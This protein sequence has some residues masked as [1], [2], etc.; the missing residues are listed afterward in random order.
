MLKTFT[1]ILLLFPL[2]LLS[3]SQ[4][5][6]SAAQIDN[7]LENAL[8]LG[9][10]IQEKA[11][12]L[13]LQ[14]YDVS[15]KINYTDGIIRS[16]L[17]AAR[18]SY[19]LGNYKDV[20]AYASEIEQIAK[21]SKN[22]DNIAEIIQLKGKAYTELGF[23]DEG[24]SELK[25]SL[26]LVENITNNDIKYFRKGFIYND[27]AVNLDKAS[28]NLD[29]ITAY[30]EKALASFKKISN[31]IMV[32]KNSCLSLSNS[33]LGSCYNRAG[34]NDLAEKF[35]LN[36][37]DLSKGG[38]NQIKAYTLLEL[39]YL[40]NSKKEFPKAGSY[41]EDGI[42]VANKLENPYIL[43][44]LYKGISESY[45]GMHDESHSKKFLKKYISLNDS[46][47][48]I[49]KKSLK[50]PINQILKEE[51]NIHE[52]SKKKWLLAI[53]G[54]LFILVVFIIL[55]I[56]NALRDKK[57]YQTLLKRLEI[58]KLDEDI[59]FQDNTNTIWPESSIA[60]GTENEILKKLNRFEATQKFLKQDVSLTTLANDLN[61]NTK[62]L[63]EAIKKH[64]KKNFNTYLNGLRVN[65]IVQKLYT[66]KV[67]GEYKISH[68]AKECGFSSRE[69]FATV[70]KKETGVSP[71]YFINSLK[72]ENNI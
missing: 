7:L 43:K 2:L 56:K 54:L 60:V 72:K 66:D 11:I 48:Q 59:A 8:R 32:R 51:Q 20:I 12:L 17:I 42:L 71:S 55:S 24:K 68:L 15:K 62:Y 30:H 53:G 38:S 40:Y 22:P 28:G 13:S 64:K 23:Y 61:T 31:N 44:D 19:D 4:G 49:E 36:A 50:E 25:R 29:S 34:K 47:S 67:Y 39:G 6:K 52:Y 1:T 26:P 57:N 69:V 18:N 9:D 16:R 33:N 10:S 37:L 3:Q 27:L 14:A 5:L 35:L 45:E 46:L 58:Q 63:S 21:T 65:F 41:F 70:F